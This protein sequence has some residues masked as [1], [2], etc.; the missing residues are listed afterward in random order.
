MY[1]K[2]SNRVSW[3]LSNSSL[4]LLLVFEYLE[5]AA[6]AERERERERKRGCGVCVGASV[7]VSIGGD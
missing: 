7:G 3:I 4:S 6:L 2:S 1:T 5:G